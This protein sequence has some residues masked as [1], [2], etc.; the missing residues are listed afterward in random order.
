[1]NFDIKTEQLGD[2]AYVISLAGEV[3]LYTAPEFKQQL[4]EVIGQGAKTSSSTSRHDVHRLDDAGR[5]RRRR[6]APADERRAASLVCT[7]R[8]ITKIFEITGLDRVFTIYPTRDEARGEARD[9]GGARLGPVVPR[10]LSA[11]SRVGVLAAGC[12]TGGISKTG[13]EPVREGALHRRMRRCHTLADAGT[14]GRSARTSTARS[15]AREQG[16]ERVDD[17]A[18]RPRPD[19]RSAVAADAAEPRHRRSTPTRSRST[20][21]RSR[22]S[23]SAA[24]KNAT[25][26]K[27]IFQSAGCTGCHTRPATAARPEG[28]PTG[29]RPEPRPGKAARSSLP[30][31][32]HER[33]GRDAAVQGPAH[34][35]R[36][37]TQSRSTSPRPPAARSSA[38]APA[39]RARG[40]RP[41]A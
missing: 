2:D 23:P 28:R 15:D 5:A 29:S 40:R 37:S 6:Q 39:L 8:N 19:R 3:D 13:D 24:A 27:E 1:M 22:A 31:T 20:S 10:R 34:A 9:G 16:F 7:D 30:S 14:H 17:P 33:H 21:P 25:D 26:G 32:R 35:T 41:R 36:R 18:R 4:L 11:R 12:G 38:R